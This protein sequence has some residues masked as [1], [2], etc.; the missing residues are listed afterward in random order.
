M[1]DFSLVINN[2]LTYMITYTPRKY[3]YF[4]F[5]HISKWIPA[6]IHIFENTSFFRLINLKETEFWLQCHNWK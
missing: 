1:H 6:P 2:Q 4:M 3:I 5:R